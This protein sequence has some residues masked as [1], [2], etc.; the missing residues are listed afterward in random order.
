MK[1][2]TNEM[3]T[4][5]GVC[6]DECCDEI[7]EDES[8]LI[9]SVAEE[10][11][12]LGLYGDIDEPTAAEMVHSMYAFMEAGKTYDEND[13]EIYKPFELVVSTHGGNALDSFAIYDVMRMVREKCDIETFGIGKVMS[14][15]V[16]ILAAGTKGKRRI[17]KNCRLML[18]AVSTV[19]AGEIHDLENEME[20]IRW[21]QQQYIRN[22]VDETD[23]TE[24]YL[25][26]LLDRKVN[27]YLTS[28]Q[29]VELGIADE[30]V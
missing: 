7:S 3:E 15:G 4:T 16:L 26:N 2:E 6:P 9:F 21:V 10:I 14:A 1:E 19:N 23:M 24:K 12:L 5:E 22:L 8:A 11:R 28:Q 20:E 17:G 18:H 29:A 30:I 27:V 13:E 25:K